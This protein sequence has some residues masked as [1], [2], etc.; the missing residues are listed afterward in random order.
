MLLDGQKI[1][2]TGTYGFLGRF[3][4]NKFS[5]L[6]ATIYGI[7]HGNLSSKDL[8]DN[9]VANYVCNELNISIKM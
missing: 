9:G 2:I 3:L 7:G 8:F 1:L 5:K 4:A 6:G